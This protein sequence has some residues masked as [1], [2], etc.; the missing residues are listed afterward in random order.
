MSIRK[1]GAALTAR[2]AFVIQSHAFGTALPNAHLG[3]GGPLR[4]PVASLPAERRI[5]EAR[6]RWSGPL[7]PQHRLAGASPVGDAFLLPR[8]PHDQGA[9]SPPLWTPSTNP[10]RIGY[11]PPF[12]VDTTKGRSCPLEPRLSRGANRAPVGYRQGFSRPEPRRRSFRAPPRPHRPRSAVDTAIAM[13][14]Q[15]IP[16]FAPSILCIRWIHS[17][18]GRE[19]CRVAGPSR[20]RVARAVPR[21][22]P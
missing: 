15:T 19:R 11:A 10:M 9:Q 5:A 6:S 17:D 4:A 20:T 22:L 14:E 7:P 3:K 16:Q 12:A 8:H 21:G 2:C 18:H 1:D 13:K